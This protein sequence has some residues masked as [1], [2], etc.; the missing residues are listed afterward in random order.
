MA[1]SSFLYA[2]FIAPYFL[3]RTHSKS[4]CGLSITPPF[5]ATNQ[6]IIQAYGVQQ[7]QMNLD[8]NNKENEMKNGFAPFLE[9][10]H[11]DPNGAY[12]IDEVQLKNLD[13]FIGHMM[14]FRALLKR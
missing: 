11:Y 6:D 3:K 2:I 7:I 14:D 9:C 10:T 4:D 5:D 8:F 12:F 1:L 13:D